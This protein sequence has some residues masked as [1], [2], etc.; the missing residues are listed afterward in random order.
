[1][2]KTLSISLFSVLLLALFAVPANVAYADC[3]NPQSYDEAVRCN[4]GQQSDGDLQSLIS[5]I[6]GILNTIIPFLVGLAVFI[7]IWGVFKYLSGAGDE[8]QRAEAKQFIIY[9]VLG[10]F[11]MVSIWGLVNILVNSFELKKDPV[12]VTAVFPASE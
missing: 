6:N 12:P 5:Q 10:V 4:S 1:M 11:L 2:L 3:A 8:E 7:I 9:G